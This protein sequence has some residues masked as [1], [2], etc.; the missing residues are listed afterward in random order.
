[1][2]DLKGNIIAN[3]N[4]E[5]AIVTRLLNFANLSNAQKVEIGLNNLMYVNDNFS[6]LILKN[7]MLEAIVS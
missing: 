4:D 5:N 6:P 7:K 1:M 3:H 2:S